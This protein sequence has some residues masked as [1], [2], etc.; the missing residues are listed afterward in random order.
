MLHATLLRNNVAPCKGT[1]SNESPI[2]SVG[3]LVNDSHALRDVRVFSVCKSLAAGQVIGRSA[4]MATFVAPLNVKIPL[5][6]KT[7]LNVKNN[8]R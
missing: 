8:L 3:L 6:V 7:P 1:F 4:M 2:R 5:N